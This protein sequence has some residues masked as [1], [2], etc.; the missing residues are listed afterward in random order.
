MDLTKILSKTHVN[1]NPHAEMISR[2]SGINLVDTD[3]YSPAEVVGA[4]FGEDF[5]KAVTTADGSLRAD[6]ETGEMFALLCRLFLK[7]KA[8][9]VVKPFALK[10]GELF[11]SPCTAMLL[12]TNPAE[13]VVNSDIPNIDWFY[14]VGKPASFSL[15]TKKR[16]IDTVDSL[17]ANKEES[18]AFFLKKGGKDANWLVAKATA[19]V[20]PD[21]KVLTSFA[22]TGVDNMIEI[23]S[24]DFDYYNFCATGAD[25]MYV[26]M[27]ICDLMARVSSI[28]QISYEVGTYK[29]EQ[30]MFIDFEGRNSSGFR[31]IMITSKDGV[32]EYSRMRRFSQVLVVESCKKVTLNGKD[33]SLLTSYGTF[34]TYMMR[35]ATAFICETGTVK[36][37]GKM[38]DKYIVSDTKTQCP[39]T[40]MED[41]GAI[42]GDRQH[43]DFLASKV[44][45]CGSKNAGSKVLA[46]WMPFGLVYEQDGMARV[47]VRK[48]EVM[49]AAVS[50][51]KTFRKE[52]VDAP[53]FRTFNL[54]RQI[55][56]NGS[57]VD[58]RRACIRMEHVPAEH[59]SKVV[60]TIEDLYLDGKSWLE[61][62]NY[63]AKDGVV[64]DPINSLVICLSSK[65]SKLIKRTAMDAAVVGV[66]KGGETRKSRLWGQKYESVNN[67]MVPAVISQHLLGAAGNA[68]C[69]D[70]EVLTLENEKSFSENPEIDCLID[71]AGVPVV[72]VVVSGEVVISTSNDGWNE[73][74][75]TEPVQLFANEEIVVFPYRAGQ[76][77]F[78][79]PVCNRV[80]G[81]YLEAVRFRRANS[82][83]KSLSLNIQVQF[84]SREKA[85]KARN[86]TKAI[87]AP[88]SPSV[89]ENELNGD[90]FAKAIF[91]ADTNKWGD[92]AK[93]KIDIV[94]A[95][96]VKN[97]N[98][99]SCK[100]GYK[101][102]RQINASIGCSNHPDL[103]WAPLAG[104]LGL[105]DALI[106]EF[107]SVFGAATWLVWNDGAGDWQETL[108]RLYTFEGKPVDGWF[109]IDLN[110]GLQD[111]V[112]LADGPLVDSR[113]NILILG[114]AT[115]GSKMIYQRGY[116]FVGTEDC[117]VYQPVKAEL[118]SP[119]D[120]I[121][122][123]DTML[124]VVRNIHK[125]DPETGVSLFKDGAKRV[126]R[127]A[128]LHM[129]AKGTAIN[130]VACVVDGK[131]LSSEAAEL[132]HSKEVMD[133]F[134]NPAYKGKTL[135]AIAK[136]LGD[137][138]LTFNGPDIKFSLNAAIIASQ[139]AN[140]KF[141]SEDSVSAVA[142]YLLRELILGKSVI[143]EEAKVLM[144]RLQSKLNSLVESSGL[145]KACA[146]GAPVLGARSA[147][148]PGI[149][150]GEIWVPESSDPRS[151]YKECLAGF[152][153][154][155]L[156]LGKFSGC[157]MYGF[158]APMTTPMVVKLVVI[159]SDDSRHKYLSP[160]Y[161]N[162]NPIIPNLH[163]GDNDGDTNYFGPLVKKVGGVYTESKIPCTTL[164]DVISSIKVRTGSDQLACLD[165]YGIDVVYGGDKYYADHN[166]IKSFK[167]VV[168][169][170]GISAKNLVLSK[171]GAADDITS[172]ERRL[173][174]STEMLV[175]VG[176]VHTFV[177][178]A[179]IFSSLVEEMTSIGL[180][181]KKDFKWIA[182]DIISKLYEI[183][184]VPLGGL[185]DYAYIALFSLIIPLSKGESIDNII[186]SPI[187]DNDFWVETLNKAGMSGNSL[188]DI[189]DS[190]TEIGNVGKI[191]EL[192]YPNEI[193]KP[194]SANLITNNYELASVATYLSLQLSKGNFSS[195]GAKGLSRHQKMLADVVDYI[196]SNDKLKEY[197]RESAVILP[198]LTFAKY[199]APAIKGHAVNLEMSLFVA[200]RNDTDDDNN[201][202]GG[203]SN[204]EDP[205]PNT[206]PSDAVDDAV[207]APAVKEGDN[208]AVATNFVKVQRWA[209]NL[210]AKVR[211]LPEW[212][213]MSNDQLMA[214]FVIVNG[215]FDCVTLTGRAGSGK[216]FVTKFAA[217]VLT[218]LGKE[219][220]VTG[221]TGVATI[222]AGGSSTI[223]SLVQIKRGS[224]D[225]LPSGHN[226]RTNAKGRMSIGRDAATNF[227][228][229]GPEVVVF[230]DEIS[231]ASPENLVLAYQALYKA[232]GR[233]RPFRFVLVGDFRQLA[234]VA[235]GE[236][237]FAF[238]DA[239]FEVKDS[240]GNYTLN[241]GSFMTSGPFNKDGDKLKK[242]WKSI[243][244]SLLTNHRQASGDEEAGEFIE[245]LNALG[246]GCSFNDQ[247]V[248]S[249]MRRV[250]VR[251]ADG[252]AKN[253]VTGEI[254]GNT[255]D[256]V[257]AFTS[258]K[259][260][261][262]HNE[263]IKNQAIKQPG[264][265]VREYVARVVSDSWGREEIS[266]YVRPIMD[267]Q[268]I[269]KG[270][271]F[272][273]RVNVP[274]SPL[275]NG[276]VGTVVSLQD[277]K[278]GLRLSNGE[279]AYL[280]NVSF[281]L[282]E[283]VNG[284]AGIFETPAMGHGANGATVWKLQGITIESGDKKT[285]DSSLVVNLKN[286]PYG[287]PH[288]LAYVFCSR[289][290]KA[291][292][293]YI[294]V[295]DLNY[296][297]QYVYCEPKVKEFIKMSEKTME[298]LLTE[299]EEYVEPEKKKFISVIR[300]RQSKSS[301][302][303]GVLVSIEGDVYDVHLDPTF[304][305]LAFKQ[306]KGSSFVSVDL[307]PEL[308]LELLEVAIQ[309]A[310]KFEKL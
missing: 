260:V 121:G 213:A 7:Q 235:E 32:Y 281:P 188:R 203:G 154:I 244:L 273:V 221:T 180:V 130:P 182:N 197:A 3:I 198:L 284:K 228:P 150:V 84:C 204:P 160:Y 30:V 230:I 183:Y 11:A 157:K 289:V 96:F 285:M 139:D 305:P 145:N 278:I 291:E 64:E 276:T 168:K 218:M 220:H 175:A 181:E 302:N 26:A 287:K 231:M 206:P 159:R 270:Q 100:N 170:N 80:D 241:F 8:N 33:M 185:D 169:S 295:D 51:R 126:N 297:E 131:M 277:K 44:R 208:K 268:Q 286:R 144:T 238:E 307:K 236:T 249:L 280:E 13:G 172:M 88:C 255:D 38:Y 123:S 128:G 195:A 39:M 250:Y 202:N 294:V 309:S 52:S 161:W 158:R 229:Y 19:M 35:F 226:D 102:L 29:G 290:Q 246:E 141:A 55:S 108:K 99:D 87:V 261:S 25:A 225:Y 24:K 223:N 178:Q 190:A 288:G 136:L 279:V 234:P 167:S 292:Q 214:V 107:D 209:N 40:A 34:I 27:K 166:K 165:E 275:K 6:R 201:N 239:K 113:T 94:A 237:K 62:G 173:T 110:F 272:M 306:Q 71:N 265:E 22:G 258:N 192:S 296:L 217:K 205:T 49:E 274:N 95:T 215:G 114:T 50:L 227:K 299:S 219:V 53:A 73:I 164:E 151:I 103:I 105:Y 251:R 264:C 111:T 17:R 162:V 266:R 256:A 199:M 271:K 143:T 283:T 163:G 176:Q 207:S 41:L 42:D 140:L 304:L 66:V 56:S 16:I 267:K 91:P 148:I 115:D 45:S 93:S 77:T 36:Q 134:S 70:D 243:A 10:P 76:G 200:P 133:V 122:F 132:L 85:I 211:A 89:F 92:L 120:N 147:G 117:P 61:H 245:A 101:M 37:I 191:L 68:Y 300:V 90:K 210:P 301:E 112:F 216:S 303:L 54:V 233:N 58:G 253:Y 153:N 15:D 174:R 177:L 28:P 65:V 152:K 263:R 269:Y 69:W 116:S 184:E 5:A 109:R 137:K 118:S 193:F 171:N 47:V 86:H 14:A 156:D 179:D 12:S 83:G 20:V 60:K 48:T 254:L 97:Q 72:E 232:I 252:T 257:H 127:A 9:G 23:S 146:F 2:T 149:P 82:A 125:L 129:M 4:V 31:R 308:K 75:W 98:H 63:Q 18:I 43:L 187:T 247:R 224:E 282:P 310:S 59:R 242:D 138:F 1:G 78:E 142:E 240:K 259:H 46:S 222:N 57:F 79:Y 298:N 106:H 155:F 293:L 119:I 104:A 21:L 194:D 81:G 124:G 212:K 135:S 186:P 262:D 67:K 189:V 74:R 196:S 248:N